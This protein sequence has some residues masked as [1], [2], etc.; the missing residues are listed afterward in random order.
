MLLKDR[1]KKIWKNCAHLD[2][3]QFQTFVLNVIKNHQR[4]KRT[5]RKIMSF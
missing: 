3:V 1:K 4:L 2:D 5:D